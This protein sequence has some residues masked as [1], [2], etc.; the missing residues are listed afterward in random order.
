M[1]DAE[2]SFSP[3]ENIIAGLKYA[4]SPVRAG[5]VRTVVRPHARV[6]GGRDY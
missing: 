4:R 1:S 3:Y 2:P 5:R 6:E